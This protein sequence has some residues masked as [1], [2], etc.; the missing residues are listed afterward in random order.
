MEFTGENKRN[1][2]ENKVRIMYL[3]KNGVVRLK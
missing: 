3:S 2:W 1:D